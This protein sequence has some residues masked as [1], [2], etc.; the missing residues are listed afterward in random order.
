MREIKVRGYA[1]EEM[2]ESQWKYGTGIYKVEFTDEYAKEIGKKYEF[3]IFTESGWVEVHGESIGQ[4]TG[5]HDKNGKEIYEGDVIQLVHPFKDRQ[6]T[7][8]IIFERGSF[9]A[10]DFWMTHYD[11]P[12]DFTEGLEHVEVIGNI[13]EH[14]HLLE[15]E[16]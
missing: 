6:Y 13:Y 3:F 5:L 14:P 11:N 16:E 10:E 8:K 7:G 2:I 9:I 12:S 4:Y 15:G 1:V